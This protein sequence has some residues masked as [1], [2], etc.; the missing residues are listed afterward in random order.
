MQSLLFN[1]AHS[2]NR[3]LKIKYFLNS[4]R[5]FNRNEVNKIFATSRNQTALLD[6]SPKS[7]YEILSVSIGERFNQIFANFQIILKSLL[8]NIEILN[9]IFLKN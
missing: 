5:T 2:L 4:A 8:I 9:P 3:L 1:K 6:R 7:L